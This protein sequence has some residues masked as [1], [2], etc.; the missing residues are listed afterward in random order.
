M[1]RI[2]TVFIALLTLS[3]ALAQTKTVKGKVTDAETGETL[4]GVNV[5]V[6]GTTKGTTTDMDGGFSIDLGANETS[7][8]FTFVGYKTNTVLVGDRTVVDVKL[9]TDVQILEDVVVVG[10]GVQ[11][12]SDITGATGSVKGEE[13]MRQPVLT[14]TQAMQGKIAG[15]QIISSGQPGSSP[16]VRIRGVGT[17]F[18]G[19]NALYVV[20]GVLTDDISNINT[21]DIVDM[22]VLKDASS[23]AIYGSR[24]ANGVIIITT[25]KGTSG[26]LKISYNNNIGIRQAANL[27]QMANAAEYSNY[28]QAATGDAPPASL[29]NTDWYGAILRNAIEQSHNISLSG[30]TDKSTFLLNVGYLNDQGIVIDNTFK[31]LTI[32]MNDEYKINNILKFGL[33]SSYSNSVNQNG[34]N[35]LDIDAYGNIGSVYN[36]A[37]RSAPTIP[38]VVDGKYGNTSAYQNVGNPVLDIK[39]NDINVKENRLQG[40]TYLELKPTTWLTVKSSIGADWRNSLNRGYN[41]QFNNDNTTF[42]IS[43]GNQYSS[44]SNLAV[45]NTQSFRWVW[46]NTATFSKKIDKSDFTFLIGAT[47]EKFNLTSFSANRKDV[48]ADQNLWYIGVGDANSSQN[49]GGGD[50]W[51]RNSYLARLNYSYDG[52]YLITATIRRD[53]SSRL[54]SQNRWQSYPSVGVAWILSK[55]GFLQNQNLF[56]FL[57]IRA[58]YG[59]VGNDQVSTNAYTNTVTQNK[60]YAFNGSVSPAVNGVQ[61]DQIKD[62]NLTWERT[63]EYDLAVEFAL[64]QSKLTGEV[65]YYDKKIENSL[66]NKPLLTTWGYDLDHLILTNAASIQNKGLEVLL[67]WKDQI[68]EN[69]S[70]TIGANVTFNKNNVVALNGGEAI[71]GGGIGAAQGFTTLTDNGHPVGSFYV[72]KT[73]GV[74]NSSQEVIDYKNQDG[75]TIQPTAKPGDFKYFDKDDN[76]KI[77]DNDRVFAGSYQPVAYYGI[78]IGVNYKKFDFSLSIYGN[79][80]NKVYNGKKAVRVSGTDNIE[81]DLVYNRW[82]NANHTQSEPSANTGNQLASDYYVESGS[83]VRINNITLGYTLPA[84]VLQRIK[85]SSL[86]VYVTSQNLF[87]YKKYSGFTAELPGD[88]LNS[89]IELSAYPTTRTISAGLNIGF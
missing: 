59:Q 70:Y 28:V 49:D 29:Y 19:T 8:S 60:P 76:G 27:V 35:N 21:A 71:R 43:G 57:K 67:N 30:G 7:L 61:I 53:G 18:S 26:K 22:N 46:D 39:D 65:N 62:P 87:T 88:P 1:R 42:V 36:D 25:R 86:R 3:S 40:S 66:I 77:D 4:P 69:W 31:R 14:A 56:D 45:K 55:E 10:Y 74:F 33:Q 50:A 6:S 47:A 78:N 13:L 9:E 52:K 38:S 32:R 84:S 75:T 23:A 51:A 73:I 11:K 15:V 16:Q 34:F 20:D 85:I 48:P 68:N 89:G 24:G 80:G 41:Y 12:K 82:T 79:A 72:L 81:K 37:Y 2:L 63:G 5:I 83:F 44:R 64:L 58:S 54:P 17:T